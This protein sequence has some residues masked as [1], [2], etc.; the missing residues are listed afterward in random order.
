MYFF[1]PHFLWIFLALELNCIIDFCRLLS[2]LHL[3]MIKT[4]LQ[5]STGISLNL[6]V[7]IHLVSCFIFFVVWNRI[8]YFIF[9]SWHPYLFLL[10]VGRKKLARRLLFERGANEDHEKSIL[11]K[12]KQ[13]FGGLFTSKME[14]MVSWPRL[15]ILNFLYVHIFCVN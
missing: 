9:T 6:I 2:C 8:Y 3:F 11:S 13:Q 4:F 5:N 12:L 7:G 10:T 15:L 14:G 1:Q